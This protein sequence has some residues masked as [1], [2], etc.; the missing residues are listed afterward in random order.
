MTISPLDLMTGRELAP[1]LSDADARMLAKELGD[2]SETQVYPRSIAAAQDS[3]FFLGRRETKKYVGILSRKSEVRNQFSGIWSSVRVGSDTVGLLLCET[4]PGNAAALRAVLP[5]L[6]P[7]PLGLR[8]SAGCGDRLGL[9]TPGHLRALCRSA[10]APIL[11]QQSIRENARTGRTPQEVMDDA[12]WGVFQEGWRAGYGADADHLKIKADIDLCAAAGYTFYTIDPGEYVD[13]QADTASFETL[14]Q[15]IG[16]LPWAE[17]E[18]SPAD[19]TQRLAGR[20]IELSD[21]R[22]TLSEEDLLRAAAKYGRVVGH[23]VNMYRHLAQVMGSRPFELEMSVDETETVTS[24]QEHVYIAHELKRLGVR[25]V[26]LAPRYVG[27][28]E[29]GVD[30][31]GDLSEF[32]RSF[33]RHLAVAKTYGP[34]KLSLHSGSDKFSIYPIVSRVAGELVHLKTAGTSYLEALRAIAQL[35]PA[36]FRKI[37]LFAVERFPADRAT[38]HVSAQIAKI[39]D[40]SSMSDLQLSGLLDNFH[41]REVLHVTFGSV[42]NHPVFREP[43]FATLRSGEEVYDQMLEKHFE[44][45]LAPFGKKP[46]GSFPESQGAFS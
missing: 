45:H 23:T 13:N 29:K 1:A 41:S 25:W 36:L 20:L 30:Y 11:A 40:V 6:L 34:Y 14:R 32:E 38:Y 10:M 26:S 5:F 19:L 33:A 3:I 16:A 24:T 17:L 15:K 31:I 43:L 21:F 42:L 27:T 9:A 2:L 28:F 46:Q 22:Q 4:K 8:K 39:P 12:M 18:S 44:K 7:Q 35:N 37:M